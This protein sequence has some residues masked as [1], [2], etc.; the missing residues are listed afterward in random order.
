MSSLSFSS[1]VTDSGDVGFSHITDLYIVDVGGTAQLYSTTRYDGVLRQWDI[2]SG[3]LSIGDTAPYFGGVIAG[4]AASITSIEDGSDAILLVGGGVN[5]ALQTVGLASDGGFAAMNPLS[6]LPASFDGFQHGVTVVLPDGTQAVFGAL[7]GQTGLARLRFEANGTLR[8]HTILQDTNPATTARISATATATVDGQQYVVTTSEIQNGL[9]ARAIDSSGN[10]LTETTIGADDGLWI[11][12]PTALETATIGGATFLILAAA[13]TDSLSVIELGTDGSMTVRD[14]VLDARDTRFGGVTSLEVVQ[15]DGKTYV[16]AGGADDGVSVFLLLAGGLL[17]HHA[18]IA[19]TDFFGLDNVSALA[20]WEGNGGIDIFVA[21]SSETGITHL[22]LDTGLAGVD[23]TA[24]LAGGLLSGTAG[25]DILQGHNGD[26]IISA[27]QG[28]DILRDGQGEDTLSGG[29]GADLFILGVDGATDTITDFTLGE[30]RLDLSLWPML[31]DISQLFFSIRSDGMTISYG[32][33]MLIVLSADG[34]PIDYR[35][36]TTADVIGAT[37]LPVGIT[38]GYPGPATPPP[39][40]GD[41]P[42]TPPTDQGGENSTLTTLQIIGAGN[43]DQLRDTMSGSGDGAPSGLTLDGSDIAETLFGSDMFDLIFAGGGDD[44]VQ[45]GQGDDTL[46]G[47]AGD[48]TLNGDDGA[49]TLLGG[50][51]ADTLGGGNGHDR[52]DGGAGDDRLDGG[53]GNDILFGQTGADTFIFNSGIDL[54]A[55]FQQGIDEIIL[56]P[57]LWTG[58]TSAADLLFVYG[59][60]E[61]GRM[62][63]DFEDGNILHIDGVTDAGTLA[64][65]IA[66]F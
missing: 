36:L 54:I 35:A 55:D 43:L 58:L 50:A 32:D 47:R 22:Q 24:A 23:L 9:T 40:L 31:R 15:S 4:G 21:S 7:A 53:A 33:E 3:V 46:F 45:G 60:F 63:I 44:I 17:V 27:G 16:L 66:L 25:D 48:D 26:D 13:G 12:A 64:D 28:D 6:S 39:Q 59:T 62:T 34:G 11:S 1:H 38:P 42:Q 65:D 19:D 61:D 20:A 49:D 14:H 18:T 8:D 10:V 5:G 37:R 30:D 41:P 57:S 56:D 29:S 2:E 51:G 52:L